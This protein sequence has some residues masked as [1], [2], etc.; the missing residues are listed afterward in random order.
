MRGSSLILTEPLAEIYRNYRVVPTFFTETQMWPLSAINRQK[1]DLAQCL[2]GREKVTVWQNN[3]CESHRCL[4]CLTNV[5]TRFASPCGHRLCCPTC[6]PELVNKCQ[7]YSVTAPNGEVVATD[8][9][10]LLWEMTVGV[11]G[12][13]SL[14]SEVLANLT[15]SMPPPSYF[16]WRGWFRADLPFFQGDITLRCSA[17]ILPHGSR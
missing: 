12:V 2:G 1:Q 11:G 6:L 3:M 17:L 14:T 15:K 10:R 5:G 4:I 8:P 13:C 9:K 7:F 16:D